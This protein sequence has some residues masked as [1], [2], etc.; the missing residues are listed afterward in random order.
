VSRCSVCLAYRRNRCYGSQ[1][2]S[3]SYLP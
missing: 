3:R 2:S 1:G